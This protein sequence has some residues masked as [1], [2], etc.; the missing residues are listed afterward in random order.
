MV[1]DSARESARKRPRESAREAAQST[2]GDNERPSKSPTHAPEEREPIHRVGPGVRTDRQ[3]TTETTIRSMMI[4]LGVE[5]NDLFMDI[6]NYALKNPVLAPFRD[7]PAETVFFSLCLRF[8]ESV[9]TKEVPCVVFLII[10]FLTDWGA[11]IMALAKVVAESKPDA[12]RGRVHIPALDYVNLWPAVMKFM[13]SRFP[14]KGWKDPKKPTFNE[15]ATLSYKLIPMTANVVS[16]VENIRYHYCKEFLRGWVRATVYRSTG[17]GYH[18][19]QAVCVPYLHLFMDE[20]LVGDILDGCPVGVV[21]IGTM[22]EH[23]YYFRYVGM[24]SDMLHDQRNTRDDTSRIGSMAPICM[25]STAWRLAVLAS[26]SKHSGDS[27]RSVLTPQL[28]PGIFELFW[29]IR[30]AAQSGIPLVEGCL[31]Y[32]PPVSDSS[33]VASAAQR[34]Q[35]SLPK[36]GP[37][38]ERRSRPAAKTL[39]PEASKGAAPK[40]KAP[41]G[42]PIRPES[43]RAKAPPRAKKPPEQPV[44][45]EAPTDGA[46]DAMND[47]FEALP[48]GSQDPNNLGMIEDGDSSSSWAN[49]EY[50]A[51]QSDDPF[52]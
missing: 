38:A 5:K 20:K 29:E 25:D 34:S 14:I 24:L 51:F 12:S 19:L 44:P 13:S 18:A 46:T 39:L 10:E 43:P 16:A 49:P 52:I 40:E 4:P 37:T 31:H 32:A 21:S 45:E 22:K 50:P 2:E 26:M 41:V 33:R 8:L 48:D 7:V 15:L 30:R 17:N 36:S 47:T 6:H 42:A 3:Q 27:I 23:H 35:K 1:A 28:A 9:D 11:S